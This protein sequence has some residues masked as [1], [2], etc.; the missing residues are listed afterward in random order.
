MSLKLVIE[1]TERT[2][3]YAWTTQPL[4]QLAATSGE[5]KVGNIMLYGIQSVMQD[6]AD[7]LNCPVHFL[8]IDP[9]NP[10]G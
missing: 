6:C 1:I 2:D 4:D 8:T 7:K 9:K 5:R 3:G 10:N